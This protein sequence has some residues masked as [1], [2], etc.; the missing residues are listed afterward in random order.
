MAK[1]I[2]DPD[3][4]TGPVKAAIFLMNLG[5]EDASA[6]FA[7]MNDDDIRKVANV[8]TRIDQVSP[9]I[10]KVVSDDFMERYQSD[11]A[12]FVE[13]KSFVKNVISAAREKDKA[14]MLMDMVEFPKKDEP[15]QWS[16]D[17]NVTTLAKYIEDEHPQTIAMIL[18]YLPPEISSEIMMSIPEERKGDIALRIVQLGQVPEEIIREVEDALR[19][20]LGNMGKSTKKAD[21]LQLMVEILNG[22]DKLTEDTIMEAIEGENNEMATNIRNM[23]F[24]FEDLAGIDDR[25]MREILK[26]VEGSQLAYA[27]K[28]SSEKMKQ[29]I[30]GNLSSRASEMLK[31]D[32]EAMGPVRLS[33]VEEAQQEIVRMAK[34]LEE[35]GKIV[36]GGKGKEDVL[37]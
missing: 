25:A 4:L 30:F 2:I 11:S 34:E 15:F 19:A 23:M 35:E 3:N 6:I 10:L 14:E 36:L 12:L 24:V 26:K 21:G 13:G 18:S 27:L 1:D 16:R 31:E 17:I 32:L 29:K 33:E 7:R 5:E 37:V 28:T 8:M 9:E 22:V 20:E